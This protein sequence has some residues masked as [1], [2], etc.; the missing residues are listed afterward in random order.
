VETAATF[1]AAAV[2][3]SHRRQTAVLNINAPNLP[4]N[5]VKGVREG[6][7]A[8]GE[9]WIASANVSG[10][11]LKIEFAGRGEAAPGTDVALYGR[12]RRRHAA[13]RHLPGDAAMPRAQPTHRMLEQSAT[14]WRTIGPRSTR[15][16]RCPIL[17]EAP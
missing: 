11:D 7:A 1:A 8:H 10:G 6:L 5:E 16:R 12:L 13:R 2:Q 4:V 9:V 17:N 15:P 3:W 14:F